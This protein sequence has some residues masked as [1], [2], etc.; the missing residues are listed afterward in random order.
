MTTS[1]RITHAWELTESEKVRLFV[2]SVIALVAAG[3]AFAVRTNILGDLAHDLF[4]GPGGEK[5]GGAVGNAFLG[6][7]ISIIVSSP[8]LDR[9]GMKPLLVLSAI[10]LA[11]GTIGVLCVQSIGSRVGIL[12]ALSGSFLVFGLGWGLIESVI[13]PLIATVYS[14][15]KTKKLNHL[16]AWWPAGLVIGSVF[17]FYCKEN[18]IGW[19]TQVA[20]TLIPVIAF[21]LL[22][23]TVRVP[24]TERAAAGISEA[25]MWKEIANPLFLVLFLCMFLTASSELAP[26]QWVDFALSHSVGMTGVV[27]LGYVSTIQFVGRHF[28]GPLAHKLSP[29]G[30]LWFSAVLAA[31]GLFLLG[32]ANSPTTAILS[33][34]VWGVGIC[35]MWPTMLATTSERFPRGG[36]LLMGLMGAA[37]MGAIFLVLPKLGLIYDAHATVAAKANG[38]ESFQA[39]KDAAG[40]TSAT[41][42][43]TQLLESVQAAAG[44][45]SFLVVAI[46]PAI[47][48]FVFGAFW[49]ADRAKGGYKVVVL[50]VPQKGDDAAT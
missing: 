49:L 47:L 44:S 4:T 34:T 45:N 32:H 9:V 10:L 30:L 50:D 27:L 15:D 5:V 28:A 7:A 8:L 38:Y 20:V 29:I 14:S 43:V 37:G 16:H 36:S 25:D 11:V 46:L 40:S 3:I 12:P 35:F 39:L 33:A 2:T 23:A 48:I 41:P 6:F 26:N 19:Q 17:A 21:G 22:A 1:P 18:H 42:A 13:N 24:S 31:L